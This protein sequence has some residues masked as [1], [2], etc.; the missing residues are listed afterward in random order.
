MATEVS[1]PHS[2]PVSETAQLHQ[3]ACLDVGC[4]LILSLLH[5]SVSGKHHN[6]FLSKLKSKNDL[7]ITL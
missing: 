2:C 6:F 5:V 1:G 4:L 3:V 7:S